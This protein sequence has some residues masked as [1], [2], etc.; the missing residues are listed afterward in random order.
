MADNKRSARKARPGQPV[1]SVKEEESA[2][3]H[4]AQTIGM[5]PAMLGVKSTGEGTKPRA[6]TPDDEAAQLKYLAELLGLSPSFF[7]INPLIPSKMTRKET[8]RESTAS[9]GTSGSKT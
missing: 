7:G 5:P 3:L 4:L 6:P 9:V 2:M 1:G 8:R